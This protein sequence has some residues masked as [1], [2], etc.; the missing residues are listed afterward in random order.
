MSTTIPTSLYSILKTATRFIFSQLHPCEVILNKSKR[1]TTSLTSS[2]IRLDYQQLS[3]GR[4]HL[5]SSDSYINVM[6]T[7]SS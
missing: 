6:L 7:G 2:S 1:G 4:G 5:R 3:L